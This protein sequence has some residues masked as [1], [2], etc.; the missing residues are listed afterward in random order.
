MAGCTHSSLS[1][2]YRA[3]FSPT[4]NLTGQVR[5]R[6]S[7]SFAYGG[8]GNVYKGQYLGSPVAVKVLKVSQES[9]T[10]DQRL[11]R[12]TRVWRLLSHPNILPLLG[13]CYDFDRP[14][15]PCLVSPYYGHGIVTS[16]LKDRPDT[17]KLPLLSQI[18]TALSYLHGIFIIHNDIRGRNIFINDSGEAC[19]AG[20]GLSRIIETERST[21]KMYS[22]ALRYAAPEL[23]LNYEGDDVNPVTTEGWRWIAGELMVDTMGDGECISRGTKATDVWSFAMT[24][25]EILTGTIPFGHIKSDAGVVLYVTSGGRPKREL[26][27]Q[28]KDHIW[29]MLERCW[30]VKPNRRPSMATLSRFFASQLTSMPAQRSRL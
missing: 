26:C 14:D 1:W 9:E 21:T 27:P 29:A 20:F 7:Y 23:G 10:A 24:V 15:I 2:T 5:K 19:L 12:E 30:D 22:G 13:H 11:L 16:Y 8:H 28:I 4:Q 18:A 25:I 6:G 17:D 3:I